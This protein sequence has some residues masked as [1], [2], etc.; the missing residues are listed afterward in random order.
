MICHALYVTRDFL[1]LKLIL[2]PFFLQIMEAEYSPRFRLNNVEEFDDVTRHNHITSQNIISHGT[3][4][5]ITSQNIMTSPD[6]PPLNITSLNVQATDEE[7][8][9]LSSPDRLVSVS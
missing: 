3:S 7:M 5:D 8:F 4:S 1:L 6:I 9:E 2:F